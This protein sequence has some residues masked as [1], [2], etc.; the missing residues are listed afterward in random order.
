MSERFDCAICQRSIGDMWNHLRNGRDRQIAPVCLGCE[1]EW[2]RGIGKPL[3]GS[4]MDRRNVTRGLALAE[5]LHTEARHQ[6]WSNCHA[7]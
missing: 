1:T 5:A 2:A 3:G 7:A 6:Q 4:F